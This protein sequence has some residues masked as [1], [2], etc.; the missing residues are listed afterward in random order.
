MTSHSLFRRALGV[1]VAAV[2]VASALAACSSAGAGSVGTVD[3]STIT[4][5]T[6]SQLKDQFQVYADAYQK[7]Y[8]KRKVK[9]EGVTDD[10]AKYTQKLATERVSK[11]L[12]DIFFN[13]DFLANTF[14]NDHVTLD[15]A[16][17]LK[18]KKDGLD[19][20]HFLPQFVGQYRPENDPKQISGLPVSADSTALAYN[21]TLFDKAGV[22]EYPK[23]DWTWDDYYRVASEIQSK[24]GGKIFGTVNTLGDG[25]NIIGF[26]PVLAASGVTLYDPKSNTVDLASSK[27]IDA[28]KSMLKFYKTASGPYTA[29]PDSPS[30]NF[31]S[32]AVAM[33]IVS[34]GSIGTIRDGLKGQEW[35]V[36]ETPTVDGKHIS[37]GGSYGLSIGATSKNPDAAFAFLGWFYDA[38]GGMTVAQTPA[39]GG[40]IPPTAD[41]LANGTWKNVDTPKNIAV[42]A[43]TAKDAVL[44][45]QLPGSASATLSDA[46]KTAAQEVELQ[47]ADPTTAYQKAQDTVNAALQTQKK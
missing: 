40:I 17:A 39:G 16:P 10:V 33:Q 8:P 6:I 42:F 18:A 15:L 36:T 3:G 5:A 35:D 25:T 22:T 23:L 30:M 29:T 1:S 27:A 24:S 45:T 7:A 31:Q 43:Q 41:G 13:V 34:R 11:T 28:W 12:P 38:K 4:I 20:N 46:L 2:T 32:G 19:L 26:G 14:A 9:I 37:G 47:G 21:K 44:Q